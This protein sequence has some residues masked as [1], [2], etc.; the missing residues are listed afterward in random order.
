MVASLGA[1]LLLVSIMPK[2]TANVRVTAATGLGMALLWLTEAGPCGIHRLLKL[3]F[4]RAG[5]EHGGK[6]AEPY[7]NLTD[8]DKCFYRWWPPGI[9][10]NSPRQRP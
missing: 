2:F 8:G 4:F 1:L 9:K 3:I 6:I 5:R 7:S 10:R